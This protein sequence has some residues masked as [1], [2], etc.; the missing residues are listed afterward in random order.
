MPV[1]RA[2]PAYAELALLRGDPS[3]GLPGVPGCRREDGGHP[4]GPTR[5][6][7]AHPGRRPRP[8]IQ[9]VQG[10]S[11]EAA[12]GHRLHRRGRPGGAGRHRRPVTTVHA[13]GH[14]AAGRRAPTQGRRAGRQARRHVV[15]RPA[16]EGA[17]RAAD[18]ELAAT[19][20]CRPRR[21]RRR[22]GTSRSPGAW[23]R[24]C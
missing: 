12:G 19:W 14:A 13:H 22:P 15:D 5:L 24:R 10:V 9:D 4:A 2:G 6:A 18:R 3:D 8:E 16:A 11:E 23:C 17:R 1:D 20:A 21:C 7:G